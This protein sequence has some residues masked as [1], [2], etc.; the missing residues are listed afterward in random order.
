MGLVH[1]LLAPVLGPLEKA[2]LV[3]LLVIFMLLQ[4]EDLRR[5]LIRLIG[6]A[7]SVP[8]RTR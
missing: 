2:A 5:R 8:P 7:A 1:Y 6:K 4:R 3:L